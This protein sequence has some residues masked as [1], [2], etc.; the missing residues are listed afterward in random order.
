MIFLHFSL[1]PPYLF[2]QVRSVVMIRDKAT[3]RHKGFAYVEMADLDVIP[4]V[5]LMNQQVCIP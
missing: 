2:L 4:A 3:N 5:L 1:P